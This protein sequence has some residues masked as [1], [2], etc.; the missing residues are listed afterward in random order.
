MV[1]VGIISYQ[2]GKKAIWLVPVTFVV[3]MMIGGILGLIN[4]GLF[5]IEIGIAMS[6]LVLGYSIY[7][8]GN[9]NIALIYLFVAFFATFHGYAHGL[10]IPVIAKSWS[11]VLGFMIGTSLIHILGVGIGHLAEKNK[12]GKNILKFSGAVISGMGL[13]MIL[14]MFGL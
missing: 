8:G 14:G 13:H 9:F 6:V 10:E 7:R 1:S 5:G 11:Y 2:V 4:I 12:N 3:V